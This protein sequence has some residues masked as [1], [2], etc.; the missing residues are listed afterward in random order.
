VCFEGINFTLTPIIPIIPNYSQLFN[1]TLTPIIHQ[2]FTQL[3]Q[4]LQLLPIIMMK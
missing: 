3:L 4:L 1:F 2:L